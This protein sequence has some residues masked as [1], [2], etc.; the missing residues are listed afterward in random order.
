MRALASSQQS[1]SRE[2]DGPTKTVEPKTRC[3]AV[4]LLAHRARVTINENIRRLPTRFALGVSL[5]ISHSRSFDHRRLARLPLT[6]ISSAFRCPTRTRLRTPSRRWRLSRSFLLIA[7]HPVSLA[8]TGERCAADCL[9]RRM[10]A[11]SAVC[12]NITEQRKC[13]LI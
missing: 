9:K 13:R 3:H 1:G 7:L 8:F 10:V 12:E 4:D 2:G 11:I 5:P 6:A